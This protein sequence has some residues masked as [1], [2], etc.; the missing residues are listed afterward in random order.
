MHKTPP[1]AREGQLLWLQLL[2]KKLHLTQAIIRSHSKRFANRPQAGMSHQALPHIRVGRSGAPSVSAAPPSCRH[3]G[4]N[5]AYGVQHSLMHMTKE[6][7]R[8]GGRAC[9][10]RHVQGHACHADA[11]HLAGPRSEMIAAPACLPS[12]R[13]FK[14]GGRDTN[15]SYA[16]CKRKLNK[17]QCNWPTARSLLKPSW[18]LRKLWSNPFP[19]DVKRAEMQPGEC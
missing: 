11:S 18:L 5:W 6:R 2:P 9:G 1:H 14:L 15:H 13:P 19:Q 3:E 10:R 7:S 16:N 17:L 4:I 8:A 12:F